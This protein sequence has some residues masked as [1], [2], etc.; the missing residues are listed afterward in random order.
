MVLTWRLHFAQVKPFI[1]EDDGNPQKF[2]R[3][4]V[5]SAEF[6]LLSSNPV[7]PQ[8]GCR[9]A[10]PSGQTAKIQITAVNDA[11]ESGPS[12]EVDAVVA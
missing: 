10:L 6:D 3:A 8:R 5:H 9:I 11:G 7:S 2:Q 1:H 4:T 12:A